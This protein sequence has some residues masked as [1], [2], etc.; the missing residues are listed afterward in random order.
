M[1][2]HTEP[3]KQNQKHAYAVRDGD[4]LSPCVLLGA[5]IDTMK[6]KTS[7]RHEDHKDADQVDIF[8]D[9]FRNHHI[10]P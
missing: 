9:C 10:T 4:R 2:Q 3:A 5:S 6:E 7:Q 1:S 8:V